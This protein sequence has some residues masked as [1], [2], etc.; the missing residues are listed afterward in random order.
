ME[1]TI[2]ISHDGRPAIRIERALPHSVVRMWD[3]LTKPEQSRTW[4]PSE[5]TVEPRVGGV[6]GFAGDPH[7]PNS[8]G[9]VLAIEP[10]RLLSFTWGGNE[11]RFELRA[12]SDQQ[13]DRVLTN[14]LE[15]EN[16]AARNAAGW[17]VCLTELERYVNGVESGGPH[18]TSALSW[19]E[20]YEHFVALGIPA[21]A[22]VPGAARVEP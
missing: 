11:L 5:L 22:E 9:T 21:G 12:V 14:V 2:F 3:A 4:F 10:P 13:V 20:R 16:E 19:Q 1:T 6:V 7:M 8:V 15:A 18:G 17:D